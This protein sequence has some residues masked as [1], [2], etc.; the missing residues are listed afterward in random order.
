MLGPRA[1]EIIA[2]VF[3]G[4]DH[5]FSHQHV[6]FAERDGA[7]V[8]M[9]SGYSA[10]QHRRSSPQALEH[11]AGRWSVRMF[12]VSLLFA[13]LLRILDSMADNDFYILAIAV[14]PELRGAGVGSMLLET[15]EEQGRASGANRLALDVSAK[16]EG[17]RRLYER[18]GF[19]RESTWPK[20][21]RI[22]VLKLHR[23]VKPL[24]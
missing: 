23:M 4:T 13:P 8:G 24:S 7:I 20:R 5:D 11:A 9:I 22:P 1:A 18:R 3:E 19:T 12:I 17:A 15:V 10:E 16:N 2:K 14:D 21:V 6:T